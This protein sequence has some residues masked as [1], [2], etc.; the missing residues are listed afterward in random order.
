MAAFPAGLEGVMGKTS[1]ITYR[2]ECIVSVSGSNSIWFS[3]CPSFDN[4]IIKPQ[5]AS[6]PQQ[7]CR[8]LPGKIT[9]PDGHLLLKA[10][11]P[12]QIAVLNLGLIC[13]LAAAACAEGAPTLFLLSSVYDDANKIIQ[14]NN[15]I[16]IYDKVNRLVQATIQG[17]FEDNF[18]SADM[19]M[20][21][22]DKDY[23]GNMPAEQD[24]TI[25]TQ[26]ELDYSARSLVLDLQTDA[27]NICRVELTPQL[28]GNRLTADQ[29]EIYYLDG[30]NYDKLDPSKWTGVKDANGRI[31]I[32][33]NPILNTSRLKIHCNFDDLDYLQLAVDNSEFY[34]SP[35][36]LVTVYQ[37]VL[38]RTETYAYDNAGNRTSEQVLVRKQSG[39][40]YSYYP[41]SNRLQ[42]KVKD[43]GTA[44]YDYTY[45]E[46]GNLTAKVVTKGST[47]DTWGY[48]YD[49]LNQLMQVMKNG[50]VVSSYI[51]DPN[52]FRVQKVGSTG[53]IDYVPLLNG[54]VGYR[55][56]FT[57]GKEYSWVYVGGTK[58]ARVDGTIGGTGAKYF[59]ANDHQGSCMVITDGNGNVVTEKD[60]SPFGERITV[61][62]DE[63]FDTEE[64]ADEFT[65][66]EY[67]SDVGLYYYNARWYDED[68]GRFISE[69]S[70]AD[71]NNPNEYTYCG[72][73][74]IDNTDPTGHI[75]FNV[76]GGMLNVACQMIPALGDILGGVSLFDSFAGNQK[77]DGKGPNQKDAVNQN[78]QTS[79]QTNV[80]TTDKEVQVKDKSGNVTK[81]YN[82]D[83]MKRD[84][85]TL[86]QM[87]QEGSEGMQDCESSLK[88]KYKEFFDAT[89]DPGGGVSVIGLRGW[90]VGTGMSKEAKDKG[91]HDY[92][93]ML[94]TVDTSGNLQSFSRVNFEGS[95]FNGNV[96][97]GRKTENLTGNYPS[98]ANGIYSLNAGKHL[99]EPE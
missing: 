28:T 40:T 87:Q 54:E 86:A 36:Q 92:N 1:A 11:I 49:L 21:T 31:I 67:D 97:V 10:G 29:I 43:D 95:T 75:G 48:S 14:R 47:V 20:G 93:D 71:P 52:G 59:Y 2:K 45:D 96:A 55:K 17:A 44:R 25:Q 42:S 22:V 85:Q 57:S 80:T 3:F 72:D 76:L 23:L 9:S 16:Y 62:L 19:N 35:D 58:L 73:S 88:N 74:P 12:K 27:T 94:L 18:T 5:P 26:I 38:S 83:D 65:G 60:H 8:L 56:E 30:F 33:F 69:D 64:T 78:N 99:N 82:K 51:Y 6:K 98:I 63:S 70:V 68:I 81:S 50:M 4:L 39:Y 15:N 53:R 46:D 24:I 79:N 37:K 91:E 32:Q 66:K 34:N 90:G 7:K 84:F 77:T 41:N 61:N 89:K 13:I